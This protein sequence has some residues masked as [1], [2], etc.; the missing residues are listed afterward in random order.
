MKAHHAEPMIRPI[1]TSGEYTT[2]RPRAIDDVHHRAVLHKGIWLHVLTADNWL[3][4]IRRS[5][6]MVTCPGGLSIVGEHSTADETDEHC[7]RRAVTEELPAFRSSAGS[8]LMHP[9]RPIPRWFLYDYPDGTRRDRSLISE[10]LFRL[11]LNS[12]VAN[13]QLRKPL[14]TGAGAHAEVE[15]SEMRFVPIAEYASRLVDAP[16]TFCAPGLLPASLI[17]SVSDICLLLRG[18]H[19]SLPVGCSALLARRRHSGI[20]SALLEEYEAKH[21]VSD[22]LLSCAGRKRPAQHA[23]KRLISKF[24][25]SG[26]FLLAGDVEPPPPGFLSSE[27]LPENLGATAIIL[28]LAFLG[29]RWLNRFMKEVLI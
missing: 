14:R 10:W 8:E 22:P 24:N 2:E 5:A 20:A 15:A 9:L 18:A 3:L 7:V 21:V 29:F 12:S 26:G 13:A 23:A 19:G 17:D 4:L 1:T 28:T 16:Q 27:T 25:C 6:S 11:E